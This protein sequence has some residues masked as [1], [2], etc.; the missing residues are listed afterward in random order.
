[1]QTLLQQ[2]APASALVNGQGDILYLYGRTGMYLEPAPG[3][4][5]INNILRMAREGLRQDLRIA[6][7]KAA[8]TA[9]TVRFAGLKVKSNGH[10]TQLNLSV[11]P[12]K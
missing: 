10:H 4:P 6:L 8:S 3:E 1:E 11:C 7:H 12:V 5:G 9:E 2:L